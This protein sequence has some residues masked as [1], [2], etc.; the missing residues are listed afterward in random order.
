MAEYP[1]RLFYPAQEVSKRCLDCKKE[2]TSNTEIIFHT[3][4]QE[5]IN[6]ERQ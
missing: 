2:L 5:T 6:E 3:C 1:T 4:E